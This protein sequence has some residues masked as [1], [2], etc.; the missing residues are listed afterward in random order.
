[1]IEVFDQAGEFGFTGNADAV[2]AEGDQDFGGEGTGVNI[3]IT[4][5]FEEYIAS[6]LI[7]HGFLRLGSVATARIA[8]DR[9]H[10]IHQ[11]SDFGFE[12]TGRFWRKAKT[13]GTLEQINSEG[14]RHFFK[15]DR[16]SSMATKGMLILG[17]CFDFDNPLVMFY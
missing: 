10:G 4:E 13:D 14:N 16:A 6:M 17:I 3:R 1:M 8:G 7:F 5:N 11:G 9:L 15:D 12:G 2:I